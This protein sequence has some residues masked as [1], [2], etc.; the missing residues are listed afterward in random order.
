M[1]DVTTDPTTP[2]GGL[3]HSPPPAPDSKTSKSNRGGAKPP[4]E[5]G[6]L[7]RAD[8]STF[9]LHTDSAQGLVT[10]RRHGTT[11]FVAANDVYAIYQQTAEQRIAADACLITLDA[12]MAALFQDI[13]NQLV[14]VSA[15]F[16]ARS[17]QGMS[18]SPVVS[19]TPIDYT[20]ADFG[21][22]YGYRFVDLV[23][24]YDQLVRELRSANYVGLVTRAE[25]LDRINTRRRL[26]RALFN[27]VSEMSRLSAPE[28]TGLIRPTPDDETF[29]KALSAAR[30]LLDNVGVSLTDE[31]VSGSQRPDFYLTAR[32][33]TNE[34]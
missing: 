12:A 28:L 14:G 4:R 9:T 11:L 23:T 32:A 16:K 19:E 10:D 33:A 21:S 22:P 3:G 18:H 24:R 27:R 30:T 13:D 7:V 1:V 5:P 34:D 15:L 26:I 29:K 17:D 25:M 6:R 8:A 20:Q 2:P 31:I